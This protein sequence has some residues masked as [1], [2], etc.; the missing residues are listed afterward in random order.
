MKVP[1]PELID[2]EN[3]EWTE[4]DFDRAVPFSALPVDLRQLLSSEKRIVPDAE[5]A[6][7]QQSAA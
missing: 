2:A 6:T 4:E 1:E 5:M 7:E 3:P